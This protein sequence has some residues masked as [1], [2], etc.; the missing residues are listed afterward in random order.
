MHVLA[1]PRGSPVV[2]G[3]AV[4]PRARAARALRGAHDGDGQRRDG[5]ARGARGAGRGRRQ[6]LVPSARAQRQGRG[7]PRHLLGAGR[8]G[9]RLLHL[10]EVPG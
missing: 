10:Q 9:A 5:G 3:G 8:Q 1:D 2:R 4:A 7:D 6:G